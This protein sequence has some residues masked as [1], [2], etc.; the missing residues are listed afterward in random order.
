M[1][2]VSDKI[3][4]CRT[5]FLA[6]IYAEYLLPKN[7]RRHFRFR[8][9]TALNQLLTILYTRIIQL[10]TNLLTLG[11]YSRKVTNSVQHIL[12]TKSKMF[13]KGF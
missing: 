13:S 6:T 9:Y 4:R 12:F 7:G 8:K 3:Q 1:F 10:I 11:K 5:N 2:L